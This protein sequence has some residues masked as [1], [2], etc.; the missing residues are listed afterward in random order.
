MGKTVKYKGFL[1]K[2]YI[3]EL[4]RAWISSNLAYLGN[5]VPLVSPK[6]WFLSKN[7]FILRFSLFDLAF[8]SLI[9]FW[10]ILL[11]QKIEFFHLAAFS[12]DLSLNFLCKSSNYWRSIGTRK[13][14]TKNSEKIHGTYLYPKVPE[15]WCNSLTIEIMFFWATL[16]LSKTRNE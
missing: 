6:Y 8:I 16:R 13:M 7:I 9:T 10:H 1:K 15:S 5:F 4:R 12:F 11:T 3:L 2:M 14:T